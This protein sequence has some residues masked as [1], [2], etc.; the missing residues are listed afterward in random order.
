MNEIWLGRGA[1][2]AGAAAAAYFGKS[3][4]ELNLDEA[5]FLAA[6]VRQPS[7]VRRGEKASLQ[8]RN[9]VLDRMRQAD[10]ISAEEV[11]SAKEQPLILRSVSGPG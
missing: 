6:L 4:A 9:F 1:Y 2:G 8:R 7:L 11:A 10:M 5:A 3:L